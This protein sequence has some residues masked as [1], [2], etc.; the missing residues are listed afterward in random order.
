MLCWV[1]CHS[2]RTHQ[3]PLGGLS[4]LHGLCGLYCL[5]HCHT[6]SLP[7]LGQLASNEDQS[8]PFFLE[9]IGL[10]LCLAPLQK[11]I[12]WEKP[13]YVSRHPCKVQH[14][15]TLYITMKVILYSCFTISAQEF[16][17]T[18]AT[19]GSIQL[20]LSQSSEAP[21]MFPLSNYRSDRVGLE[22]STDSQ[23][24]VTSHSNFLPSPPML[25]ITQ[26]LTIYSPFSNIALPPV[27][28]ALPVFLALS[29]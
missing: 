29:T 28:S 2:G 13:P 23:C 10:Q 9:S 17:S 26:C 1:C 15:L 25:Y 24:A 5:A 7:I 14:I 8:H 19:G 22:S 16:M 11:D 27:S 6:S 20:P 3:P 18:K 21:A 12:R 4:M